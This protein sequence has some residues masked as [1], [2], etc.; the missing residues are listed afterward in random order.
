MNSSTEQNPTPSA[1]GYNDFLDILRGL[2]LFAG[3]PL[4][5]TKVLA[6]LSVTETLQAGDCLVTQGE[7][8]ENFHYVICGR[9]AVSRREADKAVTVKELAE[10]GSLGGLALILGGPSLY[11]VCA[12]EETTVLT[13]GREKF[14]KT[15]ERFPQVE[16][17]MLRA[18]AGHVVAWEERFLKSHPEQCAVLGDDSGLALF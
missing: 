2:P 13:L 6:Y 18:L 1:C 17:A 10:G 7:H 3:V 4:E 15:V 11:T 14:Q 12:T 5:V 16:P 9:L 8:A